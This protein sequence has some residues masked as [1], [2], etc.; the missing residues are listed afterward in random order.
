MPKRAQQKKQEPAPQGHPQTTKTFS[1]V[2]SGQRMAGEKV[3]TAELLK[4]DKPFLVQS[5]VKRPSRFVA[6]QEYVAVQIELEGGI[7]K[8]FETM[9]A[10]VKDQLD[11]T[12]GAMPY[13]ARLTEKTSGKGKKYL[14][15]M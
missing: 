4:Y 2:Y 6:S 10:S 13:Q 15:L 12:A 7:K 9:S 14:T 3:S 5:F 11:R 8:F 1:D